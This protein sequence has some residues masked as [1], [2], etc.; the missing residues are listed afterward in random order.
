MTKRSASLTLLGVTLFSALCVWLASGLKFSYDFEAFFPQNDPETDFYIEFRESFETDNDFFIVV[1]ESDGSVFDSTFLS[2]VDS[3]NSRL[4]QVDNVVAAMGPTRLTRYVRDPVLGQVMA[5]PVLRWNEP[6]NF[7]IDST[8]IARSTGMLGYFFAEDFHSVAINIRHTEKLSKQGCDQLSLDI[9]AAVNEFGF[10]KKHLI[11]RALGQRLYVE[12]MIQELILF[13][14]LSLIL[15]T[16]FLFIAFRSAWGIIIPTL[17][18]L[19]SILWTLG[20]IRIL[21]NDLDLMLT[22]LPTIIFVVGMSDSVHVLTKYMQELRNGREKRDAIRYAFKSIRLAT[23]LTALTTSIGFLTLVLSNIEPISK[24]GIYTSVGIML[25]YGLTYTMLPAILFLATPKRLYQFASSDDFWTSKLHGSLRWIIRKRRAVILGT[26]VVC[27]ASV[28]GIMQVEVDNKMLEDLRDEHLLKQEFFFMEDHYSGCRPFEMAI[29]MGEAGQLNDKAFLHDMDTLQHWLTHVYGVGS[30]LSYNEILKNANQAMNA[31]VSDFFVVPTDSVE[32][33]RLNKFLTRKEVSDVV[34][35]HYN[36]DKKVLRIAGRIGD[37]GRIHYEQMNVELD[38]F[39]AA[40]CTS[41]F[42]YKVTGTAHLIDLNNRYLVENMV[43]D[44]LLSMVVIGLIMGI[45]YQSPKMI[46]LTI[47][48]NLI[49]L[50]I[51]GGIMGAMGIP[52][53]VSTSIVFNIAFGIAVDDTIHFLARVRT[54]LREG[55]TPMYAVKRTFLTTGKAMV[56]TTLI[57]SGGFLTLI[58]SDFLGTYYIG[59]LISLTLF[60][61]LIA[62][63]LISPLVIFYFYRKKG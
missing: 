48:P 10:P 25:A 7:A 40:N 21:G 35:L 56:V 63:M 4:S 33:R 43:W 59:L 3:L 16:L 39:I 46:L 62:E 22:I 50:V 57:L 27:A 55:L 26:V 9:E 37:F 14:S 53:K 58:L 54:L 8:D 49:P 24:F 19:I 61:A 5:L 15:T 47:I 30:L 45:V 38:R 36:E 20:F 11:G 29:M 13:I 18:V 6:E 44:L 23:F 28:Y 60:I 41:N 12:L 32:L 42:T 52:L 1:L 2:K 51:V 31:G 34:K 17:V